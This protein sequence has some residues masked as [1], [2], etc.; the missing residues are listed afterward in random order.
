[1]FTGKVCG[2]CGIRA[3]LYSWL[4]LY[5]Q[6]KR[7]QNQRTKYSVGLWET[8]TIKFDIHVGLKGVN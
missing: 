2:V 3:N 1:M 7:V 8:V 4:T 5:K 6:Q